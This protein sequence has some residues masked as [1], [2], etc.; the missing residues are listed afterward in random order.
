MTFIDSFFVD[1]LDEGRLYPE[2]LFRFAYCHSSE[3]F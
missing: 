1:Q 2:A 3:L